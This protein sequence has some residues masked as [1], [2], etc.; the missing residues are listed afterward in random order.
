MIP[1]LLGFDFAL[2]TLCWSHAFACIL[3]INMLREEPLILLIGSV[4]LVTMLSRLSSSVR[5]LRHNERNFY[6]A[7]IAALS[8]LCL[9]VA[10]ALL[11]LLFFS[12][13]TVVLYY[14]APLS[15]FIFLSM[16]PI[17][18]GAAKMML[19]AFAYA[20]ACAIPSFYFAVTLSPFEML[21]CAPI[22]FFGVL[23]F[24]FFQEHQL[25]RS[26]DEPH[27]SQCGAKVSPY[28]VP[29]GQLMLLAICI[30]QAATS[31]AYEQNVSLTLILG[32]A[33]LAA[34]SRLR[35]YYSPL[36]VDALRIPIM[37][38]APIAAVFILW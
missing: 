35:S 28:L 10:M 34:I 32:N 17:F 1:H 2:L 9:A 22:W 20:F 15:F 21:S 38:I 14:V 16:L 11:W 25:W 26:S 18:G 3:E 4:W 12:V 33:C 30:Y 7:K 29:I 24:L 31:P 6:S 23:M 36:V 27:S 19:R 8:V 37:M 5:M 13:S